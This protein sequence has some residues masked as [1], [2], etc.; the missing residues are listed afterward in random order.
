VRVP[1]TLSH[2]T[3]PPKSEEENRAQVLRDRA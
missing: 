1:G 2:D 3:R